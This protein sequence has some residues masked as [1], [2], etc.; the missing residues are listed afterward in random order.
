M[1]KV[2][3][4]Y[5]ELTQKAREQATEVGKLIGVYAAAGAALYKGA[6]EPAI[7]FESAYTGV[8]KTVD[9]TPEQLQRIKEDILDLST[10]V[11][12]AASDIAAVAEAAGQLGIAVEDI[13]NFS[14]VMINL[15]ESTNLSSE[16]AASSLAKFANITKMDADYYSN[17]GSVIVD[18]GN[19]FATTEADIVSMATR[20]A[21]T[22]EITGL[23]E[24]QT[25]AVAAAL[26][27][28][29]IE[30]EAG[31][32]SVSKLL[33][34]FEVMYQNESESL[35]DYAD[36]AGVSL[37]E[38]REI[39]GEDS[40]KAVSM[41]ISGLNDVERNGKNAVQILSDLDITEIRMSNAVLSLAASDGILTQAVDIANTAWEENSA[42]AEE[43]GKRYQTT[44]SQIQ[45][46]KNSINNAGIA[47]GEVFTPYIAE[48]ARG[49]NEF[50]QNT[51]AWIK[52]NP[53]AIKH[54]ALFV[55]KLGG[56]VLAYKSLKLAGTGVQTVGKGLQKVFAMSAGSANI[57]AAAITA[58]AVAGMAAY[59]WLKADHE[60]AVA[61]AKALADLTLYGNGAET[62]IRDLSDSI[63]DSTS[64]SYKM[65]QEINNNAR[66]YEAVKDNI[67]EARRELEFYDQAIDGGALGKDEVEALKKTFEDLAEY[68][69]QDFTGAYST[70][71][72]SFQDAVGILGDEAGIA[73]GEITKLLNS[74]KEEYDEKVS[75]T[76]E[77]ISA[78]L[79]KSMTEEGVT[80]EDS[81]QFEKDT[82]LMYELARNHSAAYNDYQSFVANMGNVDFEDEE[83]AIA[84][85]EELENYAN[86]YIEELRT[87]Q[88]NINKNNEMTLADL[89]SMYNA[90]EYTYDEYITRKDAFDQANEITNQAYEQEL[91][92]FGAMLADTAGRLN[93]QL[94]GAKVKE[95]N[96]LLSDPDTWSLVSAIASASVIRAG[97]TFQGGETDLVALGYDQLKHQALETSDES[98]QELQTYIDRLQKIAYEQPIIVPVETAYADTEKPKKRNRAAAVA[99]E[100]YAIVSAAYAGG[101]SYSADTFLAG[102]NGAEIVTNARGYQVYTA[103]ETKDIFDTYTQIVAFL[104]Q[105]QRVNAS[106]YAKAPELSSAGEGSAPINITIT[107]EQ[108]IGGNDSGS[109]EESNEELVN[110]IREVIEETY[111]DG[112]RRAFN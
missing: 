7:E 43:A 24:A 92:E 36:V 32:S 85:L 70:V 75:S 101:T 94:A 22:G 57:A 33:K 74:F 51:A 46:A 53:N 56:V 26:S 11:P 84:A 109:L 99:L 21:S 4:E 35:K 10:N 55:G 107:I 31:G 102:E 97:N 45:M 68:L 86:A 110:K 14:S 66:E 6:I 15:G 79:D 16:E 18:L 42:L 95:Y 73:A 52:E 5:D 17:L 98:Y 61:E 25:M 47:L 69:K 62:T 91:G 63:Q 19:N 71:F 58:V 105:L 108:N 3:A 87:A 40:L 104:P 93:S 103:E 12:T 83:T 80:E 88:E 30:A 72:Q 28:V 34:S 49:I 77:R 39:Y 8:L 106:A 44:E 60:A 20:L 64:E 37:K 78:Y 67:A 50:A 9:G 23:S 41:F 48:A 100:N 38:F 112:R 59:E 81:R 82:R 96:R 2:G 90:G 13:T 111:R 65:A 76:N 29:G 89:N 54:I 27:S 1:Q